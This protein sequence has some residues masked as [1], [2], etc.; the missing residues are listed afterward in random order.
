MEGGVI[1]QLLF[2]LLKVCSALPLIVLLPYSPLCWH[3]IYNFDCVSI[4][5][6]LRTTGCEAMQHH[7]QGGEEGG[8]GCLVCCGVDSDVERFRI[9]QFLGVSQFPGFAV[10]VTG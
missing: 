4:V 9:P 10:G 3:L 6:L 8:G 5:S 7:C 1:P 2:L